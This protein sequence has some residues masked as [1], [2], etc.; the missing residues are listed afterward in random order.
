M[1][2]IKIFLNLLDVIK[3]AR[4]FTSA[5]TDAYS[6]AVALHRYVQGKEQLVILLYPVTSIG[7][8]KSWQEFHEWCKQAD[9]LLRQ[10]LDQNN[11]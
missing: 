5:R 8:I 10:A 4:K 2:E 9:T 1:K 3:H 6:F 7:C 11:N